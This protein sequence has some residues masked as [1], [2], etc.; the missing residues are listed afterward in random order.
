MGNKRRNAKEA[1]REIARVLVGDRQTADSPDYAYLQKVFRHVRELLGIKPERK[2]HKL[3]N[4]PTEEELVRFFEAVWKIRWSHPEH[5]WHGVLLKLLVFCGLRN[6]E[7]VRLRIED[8]DLDGLRLRVEHGKGGKDRY[9]PLPEWVRGELGVYTSWVR[10]KG[11][12]YLFASRSNHGKPVTTRRVRQIVKE[13]ARNAGIE[14]RMYPHLFR[15]YLLT[16]LK[17]KGIEDAKLQP[18]SG[19][20][21]RKSLEVYS[22]LSLCDVSEEYQQAMEDFPVR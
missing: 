12:R 7:A 13:Y 15:H 9:V 3:P 4:L 16:F 14:K 1:A 8:V 2:S 11:R 22:R 20:E 17:R 18:I 5:A 6:E 10:E 21:Q 19:H